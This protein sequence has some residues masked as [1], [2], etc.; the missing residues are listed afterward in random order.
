LGKVEAESE[1]D[2]NQGTGLLQRLPNLGWKTEIL[3]LKGRK[4]GQGPNQK[5][6]S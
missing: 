3:G 6:G 2:H 4:V 5:V 1:K